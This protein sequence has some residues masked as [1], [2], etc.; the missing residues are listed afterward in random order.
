M[1]PSTEHAVR[2]VQRA[3]DEDD[4]TGALTLARAAYQGTADAD[5]RAELLLWLGPRAASQ[6]ID[7]L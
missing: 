5:V 4:Y 3:L 7:N 1:L 2:A 6:P